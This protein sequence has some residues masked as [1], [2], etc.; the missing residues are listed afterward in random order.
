LATGAIVL[1]STSASGEQGNGDSFGPWLSADGAKVAFSSSATN[2]MPG[3]TNGTEDIFVKDLATGAISRAST[4]ASGEQA[5][6]GSF[7]P[8]L[9]ADGTKVA[10]VSAAGNLVPGET[11]SGIFV[12]DLTTGAIS[13]ANA[14]ASGE[15]ANSGSF[16]PSLSADGT[17][18]AFLSSATNLVPGDTNGALDTFVKDLATGAIVLASTSAS[19]ELANNNTASSRPFLSADGT[20]V[21]FAS[22]ATNLVPGDTNGASDV[23]V[24][25]L[26][27]LFALG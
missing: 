2:L 16:E 12:K 25:D 22:T 20:V 26:S 17:R 23:F 4:L 6:A 7:N 15:L 3:D 9:S 11:M 18:V 27:D 21:A 14:S 19:G 10:F 8:S 24:R 13:R 1:A 5:N